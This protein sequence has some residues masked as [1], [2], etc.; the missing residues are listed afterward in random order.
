M[1]TAFFCLSILLLPGALFPATAPAAPET[2]AQREQNTPPDMVDQIDTTDIFAVP[3]DTS[4]E[5]EVVE[6]KKLEQ[7][8]KK[9]PQPNKL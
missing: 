6:N 9:T 8:Q 4:E 2:K 5:E 7:M 1:K 3:V